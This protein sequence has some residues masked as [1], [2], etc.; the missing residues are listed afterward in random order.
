[1]DPRHINESLVEK[2]GFFCETQIHNGKEKFK[3][4][5]RVL[6]L[7]KFLVQSTFHQSFGLLQSGVMETTTSSLKILSVQSTV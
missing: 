7:Y 4:F 6:R 3:N 1:M 2:R 5:S